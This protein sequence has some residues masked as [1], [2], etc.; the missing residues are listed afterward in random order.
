MLGDTL[1]GNTLWG[2]EKQKAQAL[3]QVHRGSSGKLQVS[4]QLISA[5]PTVSQLWL[6]TRVPRWRGHSTPCLC[7]SSGLL[8]G[9]DCSGHQ[10]CGQHSGGP[11]GSI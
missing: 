10:L 6:R 4:H 11:H 3:K 1:P 2:S 8:Y 9:A 5:V 7:P